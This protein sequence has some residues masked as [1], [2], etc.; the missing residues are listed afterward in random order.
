M[1]AAS[2]EVTSGRGPP[3]G[4][5]N[6]Q[7][8]HQAVAVMPSTM[9]IVKLTAGPNSRVTGVSGALS[10]KTMVLPMPFTPT[11]E[12]ITETKNGLWPC[13]SACATQSK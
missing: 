8:Q 10:A 4:R 1:A 2:R 13:Q 5:E 3:I 9:A 7:Y 6:S 12:F 11:G